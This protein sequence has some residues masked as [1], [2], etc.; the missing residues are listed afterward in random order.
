MVYT[1]DRQVKGRRE[2]RTISDDNG[3]LFATSKI[4]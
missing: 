2:L 3:A 4:R 1:Q